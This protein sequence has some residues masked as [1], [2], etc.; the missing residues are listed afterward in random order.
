MG[1]VISQRARRR[2]MPEED[3]IDKVAGKTKET[4]GKATGDRRLADEGK[5]QHSVAKVKEAA[6]DTV[7]KVTDAVKKAMKKSRHDDNN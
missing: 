5:V 1:E 2:T 3:K 6:E 7:T 4:A